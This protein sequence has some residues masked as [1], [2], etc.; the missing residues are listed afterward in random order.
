MKHDGILIKGPDKFIKQTISALDLIKKKSKKDYNKIKKYLKVIKNS[1]QSGMVL[2]KAQFN[3]ANKSAFYSV[4]WYA[5]IIIHDVHH[6][7]LHHVKKFPWKK[8]N[9]LKHEH[10][11]FDEQLRFLKKIKAPKKILEHIENFYKAGHWRPS[12]KKRYRGSW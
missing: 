11:C 5:G 4:E 7:Y 2:E 10:L 6:Y 12:F 8:K 9:F 3:V 1:K